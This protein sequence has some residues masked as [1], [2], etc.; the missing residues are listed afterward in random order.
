MK[1]EGD[2]L[3]VGDEISSL[4]LLTGLLEQEGYSVRPAETGQMAIDSAQARPPTLILLDIRMPDM[5]GYEVCRQ[6]HQD[7]GTRDVPIIF[8]SSLHDAEDRVRGFEAGC[9]DFISKPFREQEILA[10]VK[11]HTHLR[12]LQLDL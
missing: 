4:K 9:V 11:T 3:I 8:I 7:E 10:R 2:I 6:L 5:D 12:S 1:A